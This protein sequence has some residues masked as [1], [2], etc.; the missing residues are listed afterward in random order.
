MLISGQSNQ[1]Q[2]FPDKLLILK[3][4]E[5]CDFHFLWFEKKVPTAI[6]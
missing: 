2:D 5:F 3:V 1:I 4:L 6:H